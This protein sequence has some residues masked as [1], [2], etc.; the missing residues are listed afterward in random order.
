MGLNAFA[1]NLILNRHY[2]QQTQAITPPRLGGLAKNNSTRFSFH[3]GVCSI[4]RDVSNC[5]L[6][7]YPLLSPEL[8][9]PR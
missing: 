9:P 7:F 3:P 4:P 8:G 1:G 2:H 6:A 5:F